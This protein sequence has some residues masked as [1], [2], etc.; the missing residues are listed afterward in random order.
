MNAG[1]VADASLAIAWV[2]DSQSSRDADQ[3]LQDIVSGT[4]FFVPSLWKFEV[5][6]TLLVLLRRRRIDTTSYKGA[7][8]DISQLTPVFDD[9][10]RQIWEQI[11]DL[12]ENYRLSVYDATYLELALRRHL[13][14][15]SR[16]AAL[17]K[18]AKA[19]GV[20]TLL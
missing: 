17:N 9:S 4:P 15:A 20:K 11:W 19:S 2:I 3:L 1:F 18:A 12:A 7:R 13:P 5:A 14:L 16:D 8:R 6:N 10:P